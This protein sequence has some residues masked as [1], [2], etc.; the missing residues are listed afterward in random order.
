VVF[1]I[2]VV[3]AGFVNMQTGDCYGESI[4]LGVKSNP[5]YDTDVMRTQLGMGTDTQE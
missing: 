1:V 2:T 4:S 5:E 3:S